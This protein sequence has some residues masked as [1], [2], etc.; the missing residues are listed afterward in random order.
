MRERFVVENRHADNQPDHGFER[1]FTFTQSHCI[2]Q[3]KSLLNE[4]V[5]KKV[6]KALDLF[7]GG[8]I[9]NAEGL[10]QFHLKRAP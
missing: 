7:G 10:G 3:G 9:N 6:G 5:G 4:V 8:K 1:E 2:S